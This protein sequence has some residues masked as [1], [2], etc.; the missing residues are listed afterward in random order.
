MTNQNIIHTLSKWRHEHKYRI[1]HLTVADVQQHI[2]MHPLG[3]YTHFPSR[4]V[5]SIYFDTPDRQGYLTNLEGVG[6]RKKFRLRWYDSLEPGKMPYRKEIKV[7]NSL[8]GRK[9]IEAQSPFSMDQWGDQIEAIIRWYSPTLHLEPI[10]VVSYCRHY[11]TI[12]S[13][14]YR[15]TLDEQLQY[16]PFQQNFPEIQP[17]LD[18][19]LVLEL[20]YDAPFE[21]QAQLVRQWIPF[22]Q[23]KNSKY[24]EA[25]RRLFG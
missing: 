9:R 1:E 19:G 16:R 13:G 8:L 7:R 17:I 10:L 20:K 25:T 3:F 5:H 23:T 6:H 12:S 24:A 22:R 2:R 18:L 21:D 4:W 14:K 11:Y 15:L